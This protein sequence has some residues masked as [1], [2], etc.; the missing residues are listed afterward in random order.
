[1]TAMGS[2]T[3]R[4]VAA[5]GKNLYDFCVERED[6]TLLDQWDGEKNGKLS[7]RDVAPASQ[8]IVWWVCPRGHEWR[9]QVKARTRGS[10]CPYCSNRR[11]KAGE[12]DLTTTHPHLASQW[13]PDRN[14][15]L[16]PRDVVAGSRRKVWWLCQK[17][18]SW[19][20]SILS[21]RAG[22]G[23]PV[24]AG[25]QVI[26]G[27]NDLRSAYPAVAVQWDPVL[28]G[29]LTPGQ[30]TPYS[31]RSVWWS[32]PLGHSW[33]AS[34][35]NRTRM[36]SGCPYC[37]GRKVLP[38]FNDLATKEP[39]LSRQWNQELN[40]TL[41]PQMVTR[42]S[43][44]KVWWTCSV[45]HVWKASIASRTGAKRHGCPICAG[46]SRTKTG[47]YPEILVTN[48]SKEVKEN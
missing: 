41:T 14:D 17:G 30:V 2:A 23:C 34:V 25:K 15:S 9:A 44:K 20:A 39:E 13:H 46:K 4:V 47:Y 22:A 26:P 42:A 18:H 33:R 38:G 27:E 43:N 40:G 35:A 16:T 11:V 28:N 1:M 37:A 45:G 7:P 32:C 19:Q 36:A 24:C 5:M 48:L 29:K 6:R 31:N 8:R 3:R 10:G 12:N 21:R